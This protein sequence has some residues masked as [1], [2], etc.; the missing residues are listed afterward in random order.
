MLGWIACAALLGSGT[1]RA[2]LL[3]EVT[4]TGTVEFNSIGPPPLGS[5]EVGDSASLHFIVDSSNF[6]NSGMFPTRGYPILASTFSMDFPA[7]SIGLASPFPPG[8]TPYFVLRN[9]DPAV[10]G[11]FLST[12]LSSS[13]GV[14][15][16]QMGSSGPLLDDFSVT[17]GGSELSSLDILDALGTYD[18]TGLTVFNWT[19]D[20]GEQQPMG[21]LFEQMVVALSGAPG[22]SSPQDQAATQMRASWIAAGGRIQVS[23]TPACSASSHTIYY[24]PLQDVASY[25]YTGARCGIGV[26]GTALF[27]PP[28]GNLFFLVVGT[29]GTREGSYGRDSS[30]VER[31]ES[32]GAATCDVPQDLDGVLCR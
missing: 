27:V 4:V 10:D 15:L 18:F 25:R 31:P 5:V 22:A 28:P 9:N 20:D 32:V 26:S 14:P 7:V 2:G 8:Q 17:Y 16:D 12:N 24:G 11:F 21:I 1:V 30:G 23:Y 19:V 29:D 6:V 3:V 13:T